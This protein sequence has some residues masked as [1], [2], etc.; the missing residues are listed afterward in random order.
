MGNKIPLTN[1]NGGFQLTYS[2]R[3]NQSGG[4]VTGTGAD[5]FGPLNPMNPIA[6]PDVKGRILDYPVG[7]NLNV[8]PRSYQAITFPMLRAFADSY[9]LLRI[10]IETRKDQMAKMTWNIVPRDKSMRKRGAK[11]PPEMSDRCT[12]IEEFFLMPDKENFWDDWLRMLLEDLFVIDAPTLYR[13][14]TFGG[15]MYAY[16]A[17]D[18]GLIK[19]VIDDWGNTPEPPLPAYQQVLKGYPAVDYTTE[20]LIYRP[21]VKRTHQIYGFGPVEQI[22]MTINIGLRRQTWQLESFTEGNIPEALI[23]TP[24]TWTPDQVRQF[25]D[26]F[27]ASLQGN[28][29][30]RSRARFV[31]GGVA[32]GYV[33]TKP[34][35]LFGQAEEWLARIVCHAFSISPQP[36]VAQMN[37]A[38]AETAQETAVSE[39]LAPIQNWVKSLMNYIL[40]TDFAAPDLEFI[41]EDG[42]ELDPNIK[43]EIVDREQ[44]S[45]RLTYNEARREMGDDPFDHPDADRPMFKTAAGWVPIFLTPEEQAAKDAAAL[46]LADAMGTTEGAGSEKPDAN[47]GEGGEGKSGPPSAPQEDGAEKL[48]KGYNE[49]QPRD[50]LGR[51]GESGGPGAVGGHGGADPSG[52]GKGTSSA[53]TSHKDEY[54]RDQARQYQE[55]AAKA[56]ADTYAHMAANP[57]LT[58]KQQTDFYRSREKH[59]DGERQKAYSAGRKEAIN[60]DKEA[61]RAAKSGVAEKGDTPFLDKGHV[62]GPGCGHTLA[63]AGKTIAPKPGDKFPHPLRPSARKIEKKLSYQLYEV[64]TRAKQSI[65]EQVKFGLDKIVKAEYPEDFDLDQFLDDLDLDVFSISEED[66]A[67]AIEAIGAD[68]SRIALSQLGQV[69]NSGLVEQVNRRALEY[70]RDRSAELVS[71][72]E[73]AD[74]LLVSSTRDMIRATIAQ[75]IEDNLSTGAIGD[76]LEENYAFSEERADTIASTEIT[77]ANSMGAL[78]SY[79]E[80]KDAGVNVK[81]SW[82]ILEDA[83]DVCQENADAGAIDLDEPFPSGDMAPGAHPHCRCVLVPEVE[84]EDGNVTEGEEEDAVEQSSKTND[85]R[86]DWNEED[87]PR[88]EH[89]RFGEGG[90]S[91]DAFKDD[92]FQ[93]AMDDAKYVPQDLKDRFPLEQAVAIDLYAHYEYE[94]VNRGL[95]NDSLKGYGKAIVEGVDRSMSPSTEDAVLYRGL[96]DAKGYGSFKEGKEV[97]QSMYL[98]TSTDKEIA[99]QFSSEKGAVL[100]IT[101]P[102][103]TGSISLT[104]GGRVEK[105]VILDRGLKLSMGPSRTETIGGK[106]VKVVTATVV[107]DPHAHGGSDPTGHGAQKADFW[108]RDNRDDMA[109]YFPVDADGR[110]HIWAMGGNSPEAVAER[111]AS[112]LQFV[113]FDQCI[114][115]QYYCDHDKVELYRDDPTA[116]GFEPMAYYDGLNYYIQ[117]GH[118]R[119]VAAKLSGNAGMSMSVKVLASD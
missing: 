89:G 16:Q 48:A 41:W 109:T 80:A 94:D 69:D 32:K 85:L 1:G 87:H 115:T 10:I 35:E 60:R 110:G 65:V 57:D 44:A 95:R 19:R 66:L 14:R 36:F 46:A 23:G 117:D 105:E 73:D 5:W 58:P 100:E 68:A 114:A 106:E 77:T 33:P 107:L 76:L 86:K 17:L 51:F 13:R 98:S 21:R 4:I 103:G 75:G 52:H 11:V 101:V 81:K 102:K 82:L 112:L 71:F 47:G 28:T 92:T 62:H 64:L 70:A 54:D 99:A 3:A 59:Y 9:D 22:I 7:Y 18:G 29:A 83:C 2:Q 63:K 74:P 90:G 56:R 6:P 72:D 88:D 39:G 26:W 31:P 116:K 119:A 45:G 104:E 20:E 38:T 118:H 8:Q 40:I 93:R 34:S 43:S 42:E 67:T 37:R 30:E 24:D 96:M 91:N 78:A 27:D 53:V 111:E 97:S 49:D 50:E 79:E 108:K 113:P 15:E 55:N 61:R 12:A 25:Q 84:D